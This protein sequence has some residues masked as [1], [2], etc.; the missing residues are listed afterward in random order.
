MEGKA[1]PIFKHR[2]L[3]AGIQWEAVLEPCDLGNGFSR[4]DAMN[5]Q[6]LIGEEVEF[7]GGEGDDSWREGAVLAYM[8]L[9]SPHCSSGSRLRELGD[10]EIEEVRVQPHPL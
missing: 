1:L 5:Q 8:L 7:G 3:L 2:Y 6:L 4:Y 9:D 10:P